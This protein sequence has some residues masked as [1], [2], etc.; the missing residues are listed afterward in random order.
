MAP[1][2]LQGYKGAGVFEGIEGFGEGLRRQT[3]EEPHDVAGSDDSGTASAT[4]RV[5]AS[6]GNSLSLSCPPEVCSFM[7]KVT[8]KRSC[9]FATPKPDFGRKSRTFLGAG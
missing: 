8:K 4:F 2:E 5:F 3:V 6:P 9:L 7:R 1:T